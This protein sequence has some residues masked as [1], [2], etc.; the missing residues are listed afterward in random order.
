MPPVAV[1]TDSTHYLPRELVEAADLRLVSLYVNWPGIQEREVD[2]ADFDDFYERLGATRELPTT[3]QPSIGDFLAVY[4]PLLAQGHDV[5]SIHLAG[6]ISGTVD[7][8]RQAAAQLAERGASA[9]RVEV[10]DSETAC[11][12]MGLVALAAARAA[13]DGA[14]VEGV[15][16]AARDARADLKIWFAVDS[17]EY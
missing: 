9:P 13:H 16:A 8:A 3:S 4:E 1:V 10:L 15:I 17:L 12:G 6:G 11:G 14:D 2:M 5:V 7:A